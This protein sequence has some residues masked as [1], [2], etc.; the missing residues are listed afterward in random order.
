MEAGVSYKNISP[1]DFLVECLSRQT[2]LPDPVLIWVG[3]GRNREARKEWGCPWSNLGYFLLH[4][5]G[6][7]EFF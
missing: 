6:I 2:C 4:L 5:Q 1:L 7:R 3:K